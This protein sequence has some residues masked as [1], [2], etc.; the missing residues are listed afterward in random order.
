MVTDVIAMI[1]QVTVLGADSDWWVDTGATCYVCSNKEWFTTYTLTSE[2]VMVSNQAQAEVQEIGTV[3]LKPTSGK[4]LT[5][6]DVKH[7]PAI[8]KNLISGGLLCN[9]GLR[10]DINA[11]QMVMSIKGTYFGK[12]FYTEGMFKLQLV[13]QSHEINA[14]A[15]SDYT[16]ELW[17]NRLGHVYCKTINK[18]SSLGLI[19]KC[20]GK[21]EK[22]E[23]CAQT[24]I[25]R[26]PFPRV[27]RSTDLLELVHSDICDFKQFSTKVGIK[28]FITFIDDFSKYAFVYLLKSKYEAFEKFKEFKAEA[29]RQTGQ[30]KRIR[31]DQGGEYR[32]HEF[33]S[34]CKEHGIINET[35]APYSP[36]SNGVAERKNKMLTKIINSMLLTAGLPKCY[37]GEAALTTTFILNRVLYAT[38]GITAYELWFKVRPNLN[39]I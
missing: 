2:V 25:T 29:E 35:T 28:Y 34:F 22:C 31:S 37:W 13:N 33:V 10:M 16:L 7:V 9:A 12:A 17:H 24:K 5:L 11:G 3:V 27:N 20:G 26:K 23:V 19:S 8:A 38:S 32:S 6:Q 30:L 1:A 36:Q 14:I 21:V 39:I 18:M 15:H 4:S